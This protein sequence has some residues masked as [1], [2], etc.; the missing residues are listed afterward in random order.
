MNNSI[1]INGI[2]VIYNKYYKRY[3]CLGKT[4]I[5]LIEVQNYIEEHYDE[6]IN[7]KFKINKYNAWKDDRFEIKRTRKKQIRSK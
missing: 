7:C 3:V 5:N 4:F 1:D 2:E 6:L